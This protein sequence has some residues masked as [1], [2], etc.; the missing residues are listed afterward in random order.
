MLLLLDIR[1]ILS[2]ELLIEIQQLQLLIHVGFPTYLH[3]FQIIKYN[4]EQNGIFFLMDYSTNKINLGNF[5]FKKC[6]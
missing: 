2:L 4:I 5:L 1:Q 6:L 3:N